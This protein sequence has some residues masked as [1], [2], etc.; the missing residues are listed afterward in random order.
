MDPDVILSS[1]K[2]LPGSSTL[3]E[4]SSS[5]MLQI[6]GR[7]SAVER[8]NRA[9]LEELVRWQSDLKATSRRQ[10][11]VWREERRE[12]LQLRENTRANNDVLAQLHHRVK[13]TEEGVSTL[14]Q[15]HGVH[16]EQLQH[17]EQQVRQISSTGTLIS[18]WSCVHVSAKKQTSWFSPGSLFES[19][20]VIM[21]KNC[22]YVIELRI[23]KVKYTKINTCCC[24]HTHMPRHAHTHRCTHAHS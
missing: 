24:M 20:S 14:R 4:V 8:G 2:R 16:R 3:V 11:D 18:L 5:R 13:A 17:T 22:M 10:D 21:S 9:L 7:L 19:T 23:Y 12:L 6:E 15:A 1:R